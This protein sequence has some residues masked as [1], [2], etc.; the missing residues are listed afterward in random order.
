MAQTQTQSPRDNRSG[1]DPG[2]AAPAEVEHPTDLAEVDCF[3]RLDP[4]GLLHPVRVWDVHAQRKAVCR[5]QRPAVPRVRQDDARIGPDR[6]ELD[7]LVE[8]VVGQ[9]VRVAC[10]GQRLCIGED[11]SETEGT[12]ETNQGEQGWR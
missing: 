6:G 1:S 9:H 5:G 8:A 3:N 12:I 7:G 4:L 10:R 11:V 2:A